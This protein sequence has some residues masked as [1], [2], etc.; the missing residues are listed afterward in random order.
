MFICLQLT[1]ISP[2]EQNTEGTTDTCILYLFDEFIDDLVD[3]TAKDNLNL[4]ENISVNFLFIHF[5][6]SKKIF[7]AEMC[8]KK[9]KYGCL[10]MSCM[11]H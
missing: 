10:G 8:F 3:F 4:G 9:R 6:V 2:Q 7:S 11:L 1:G 5:D